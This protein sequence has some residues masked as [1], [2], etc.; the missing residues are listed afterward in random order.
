MNMNLTRPQKLIYDMEKFTG[1]TIAVLCGAMLVRGEKPLVEIKRAA[2]ELCRLNDALRIRIDESEDEVSQVV[3]DYA[4]RDFSVLRFDTRDALDSY[5]EKYAKLPLDLHGDLCEINIVILPK[6]YGLLVKMHHLIGDAWS[7][8][9]IGTQFN[10]LLNGETIETYSYADYVASENSYIQ[11]KRYE[12][13]KAYF[14]D[15]FKRCDEVTYLN[16]KNVDTSDA[17]RKTF[18]IG[19]ADADRIKAY[20]KAKDTSAFMLFAAALSVYINRTK[21]NAE[22][23][24]IGT[25]VLNRNGAKEQ[26]TAGMFVNTA[27]MLIELDNDSSFAENLASIEET[28]LSVFRHQ[29]FN[30]GDLLTAIRKDYGFNEKLYDVI[31]SYQNA[32]VAGADVETVWYHSGMQSESLQMHIDDRDRDGIYRIH[33]DYLTEKFSAQEIEGLHAHLVSL[34]FDAIRND[35]KKLYELDILP[36]AEKQ[37]LLHT[38]NDTAV[39]YPKDRCVHQLFEAQVAKTPHKTA[40]IAADKTLTY[41]ELNAEANRIAHSLV[42]KGI[43][44]NDII[45]FQVSRKSCLVALMLGILK[46]GAS[47]MP[48]DPAY[49]KDRVDYMVKDI[50]AKFCVADEMVQA[51]AE[52]ENSDNLRIYNSQQEIFCVLHTSGSTGQPKG[53]AIKHQNMVNF[54]YSNMYLLDGIEHVIAINTV[55]FDVFEMDTI[56]ALTTGTTCVLADEEQ[57][58]N[59]AAF[60]AMMENT[61]TACFGQRLQKSEII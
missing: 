29:R 3:C 30:Y 32:T 48:I 23:F 35:A 49:P 59:Q 10:R 6:Q 12:K 24:Y 47:Y 14:V 44:K 4:E 18:V 17:C 58:F 27:P 1:G 56:F 11:G 40:L 5:A 8:A 54:I 60:E 31:L 19:K 41:A 15:L 45:A 55:T 20:A 46:S 13:D 61:R 2:S 42:E 9:L 53:A 39:E 36:P 37:R 22:R 52:H 28:V 38:F 7:F 25:A 50:G 57:Q 34:L 43:G 26:N 33:Y 51:L 21:M 16:E